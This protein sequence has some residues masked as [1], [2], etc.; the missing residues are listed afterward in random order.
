MLAELVEPE[1]V[2]CDVHVR[3][4]KH[5]L[6][7]LGEM[8]AKANPPMNAEEVFASLFERE[9]LGSTALE[10][11]VAF[12]HCRFEGLKASRGALLKLAEAIDFDAPDGR[13]VDLVF[14]L[15]V[16]QEI[17]EA[18]RAEVDTIA[19]LLS[20]SRVRRRLRSAPTGGELYSKLLQGSETAPPRGR[21][22]TPSRRT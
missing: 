5:C 11:G 8:L 3:S 12:P 9:R 16:P 1:S 17:T 18:H 10:K 15:M 4:K 21:A 14:G 13:R 22:R 6:E 2:A 20:D 7:V 19:A